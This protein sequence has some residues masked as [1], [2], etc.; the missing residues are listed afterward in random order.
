MSTMI[1][2]TPPMAVKFI[3]YSKVVGGLAIC[4]GID[5]LTGLHS[6]FIADD[7]MDPSTSVP[8]VPQEFVHHVTY[9]RNVYGY[10]SPDGV[11]ENELGTLRIVQQRE[12]D[13]Q[14][15]IYSISSSSVENARKLYSGVR[16]GKI[17][18]TEVYGTQYLK[19]EV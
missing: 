3:K 13:R 9:R 11:Y 8:S 15:D 1:W 17:P 2:F 16:T 6:V 12:G 4:P 14:Y 7:I 10:K 18:L 5:P 19:P